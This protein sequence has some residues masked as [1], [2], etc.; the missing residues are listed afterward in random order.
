MLTLQ[1]KG[2]KLLKIFWICNRWCTLSCEYLR[3]GISRDINHGSDTNNSRDSYKSSGT[4]ISRDINDGSDTNNSRDTYQS[5]GTGISRDINDGS[6]T[7]NSRDTYQSSGTGI[8]RDINDGSDTNNSRDTNC[9]AKAFYSCPALI[10]HRP[11]SQ[12]TPKEP[13]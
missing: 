8:C 7:N 1:L 5:S 2:V 13:Q 6:D 3:T 11:E 10:S 4:G 9:A 12:K